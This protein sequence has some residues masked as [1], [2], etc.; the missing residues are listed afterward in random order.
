MQQDRTSIP[1]HVPPE[2][3]RDFDYFSIEPVDGDIHL[4]WKRWQDEAPELF[5]TPHSGGHWVVTRGADIEAIFHDP[6]RF[7]SIVANIP[8][9]AKPFRLPML[10]YDPPEHAAHKALLGPTFSP[11]SINRLETFIRELTVRLIEEMAPRGEC[12]FISEFSQHMPIGVF[13]H[14]AGLPAEEAGDLLPWADLVTRAPDSADQLRGF[15]KVVEY[16]EIKL[17]ERQGKPGDKLLDV[18]LTGSV[19]DRELEFQEALALSSLVMFAGLD[20][21]VSSMGFFIRH[22]SLYPAHRR[23]L[24]A[25]PSLI[26][27]A[28][29]EILRRHGVTQM[30]RTVKQDM[31]YKGVTLKADEMVLL[32]TLWYGLDE[33]LFENP[34]EV[35]FDRSNRKHLAFGSG[36]HRCLGSMLARTELRVMIEEWLARIPEFWIKPG[37]QVKVRSGKVNAIS[38]LPL[39]W[40]VEPLSRTI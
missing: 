10:E 28:I 14:I 12:E 30:A 1:A 33:Q 19:N 11:D 21:V 32:A 15:N 22:L 40:E 17:R 13:M 27:R 6:E 16:L 4:G 20:T 3:V 9:E 36:A 39:Q 18:I 35:D 34:L 2:L 31:R 5:W 37:E 29:E 26:P 7:S 24:I 23:R 25:E 8:K 38:H